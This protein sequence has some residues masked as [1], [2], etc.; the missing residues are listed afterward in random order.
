MA[1]KKEKKVVTGKDA[2]QVTLL[3]YSIKMV[4]P[5]GQYANIQPEIVVNAGSPEVALEYIAPHMNKLWKEY[6]MI[7]ERRPEEKKVVPTMPA[8]SAVSQS[9]VAEMEKELAKPT[10]TMTST[11]VDAN[12]VSSVAFTK[13]TQAINSCMSVEALKLITDQ[14]DRSVKLNDDEKKA[15]QKTIAD[16]FL[17]LNTNPSGEQ[18]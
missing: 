18:K 17:L 4:I 1:T 13:A 6:Y 2:K 5:T 9:P 10:M 11:A 12:P 15:L 16:K 14:V 3:T 7:S 8:V